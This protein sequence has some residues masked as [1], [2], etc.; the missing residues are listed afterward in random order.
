[1][2]RRVL[3]GTAT[4]LAALALIAPSASAGDQ[5]ASRLAGEWNS[6]SLRMDDVGYHFRL[7][8][9]P[10][11]GQ[12]AATM[13]MI[14][15]DGRRGPLARGRLSVDGADVTLRMQTR[16]GYFPHG[17]V[18][19]GTIGQDGS[20]FFARCA[21]TLAYVSAGDAAE[22]CLFQQFSR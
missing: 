1:M 7:A 18:L 9:T 5:P 10:E 4:G 15:Q 12:Y 16:G 17:A 20:I 14:Y 6:V 22:M 21:K 3:L 19:H 13:R 11:P 8:P 2:V